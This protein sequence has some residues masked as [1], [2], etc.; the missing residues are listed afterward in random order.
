MDSLHLEKT[1]GL[2]TD[3]WHMPY[4]LEFMI[5][6]DKKAGRDLRSTWPVTTWS[7][8][9]DRAWLQLTDWGCL[10]V[11]RC[12]LPL[13]VNWI[14]RQVAFIEEQ[15]CSSAPQEIAQLASSIRRNSICPTPNRSRFPCNIRL[16]MM[17]FNWF[18][19]VGEVLN[20]PNCQKK[21]RN[22]S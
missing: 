9:S 21:N 2:P 16:A 15:L 22:L 8:G 11:V 19:S 4:F 7:I 17:H 3:S 18:M 10:Q 20:T 5:V 14:R 13:L 12:Q 6:D 1:Q